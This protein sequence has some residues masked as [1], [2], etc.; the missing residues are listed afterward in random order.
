[1]KRIAGSALFVLCA[2]ACG[3]HHAAKT[4]RPAAEAVVVSKV[5]ASKQ[6]ESFGFF[7]HQVERRRCRI[8]EGGPTVHRIA[9][10]CATRVRFPPG[11]SGQSRVLLTETWAWRAFH[12]SGSPKRP[13]HH[14]WRFTLLPTGRVIASGSGGD[15]P[16][17]YVR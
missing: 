7:P 11:H 15:F 13:Q 1:M 14:T 16:P 3:S 9:G 10:E 2:T 8:P 12:Y 4:S 6:A 17:Q 5:L